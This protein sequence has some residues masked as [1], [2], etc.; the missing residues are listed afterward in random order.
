MSE[1][2]QPK[3]RARGRAYGR[4]RGVP[5]ASQQLQQQVSQ[6]PAPTQQP[7]QVP[8]SQYQLPS[9]SSQQPPIFPPAQQ[10]PVQ[11]RPSAR[12]RGNVPKQMQS[13]ASGVQQARQQQER[14]QERQQQERLQQE[15]QKQQEQGGAY[16]IDPS[17]KE[18]TGSFKAMSVGE[19][20]PPQQGL[21]RGVMRGRLEVVAPPPITRPETL[22]VKRGTMGKPVNLITNHFRLVKTT[23]W[24]LYQYRVDFSPDDESTKLRKGLLGNHKD[25]LGG[26]AYFFD[27]SML[28]VIQRLY[29]PQ[30]NELEL[31]SFK[32]IKNPEEGQPAEVP[33]KITIRFTK[34]L[35]VGDYQYIQLFN[36]ILRNC[37]D[38]MEFQLVGREYFDPSQ[39]L[40]IKNYNLEIWPGYSTSILQYE[41]HIM[42]GLDVSHKVLRSDNVWQFLKACRERFG[43][44]WQKYFLEVILG[45]VV[46]TYYNNKPYRVDD[47]AFDMT[48]LDTFKK[49]NSDVSYLDYYRVKHQ[50]EIKEPNQPLLISRPKARDI[51]GGRNQNIVLI[52]E[53]CQMTG[54]SDEMRSNFN[55]MKAVAD[56]TRVPPNDRVNSYNN[57]IKQINECEKATYKL[58][59]WNVQFAQTLEPVSGRLFDGEVLY[60]ANNFQIKPQDGDWSRALRQCGMLASVRL[61]KWILIASK[62]ATY[63]KR[64]HGNAIDNFL[65]ELNKAARS[66][67]FE[68]RRPDVVIIDVDKI[69]NYLTVI[70][71]AINS[72]G[73]QLVM[74][75][76]NGN[77][78]DLYAAIK[79]K[80]VCDRPIPSQV[81]ATKTLGHKSLLSVCT[82]IVIQMNCKLG[83]S[84]WFTPVPFKDKV[85]MSNGK[86]VENMVHATMIVGFDVCHDTR[87]KGKSVGAM[88][89]SLDYNFSK[90]YSSVSRHSL[91]EELSNDIATHVSHAVIK[92]QEINE[93]LPPKIIMFRDGVGESNIK[94]VIEHEVLTI[95]NRLAQMFPHR[96]PK[97]TVIIVSKRIQ[98]RFFL[99]KGSH[100]LNPPPG[101][102]VDDVVTQPEKYDFFLVSQS[103]RQGT[104]TPTNYNVIFDESKL[105]PDHVQRLAYKMCHL[106][107][108]CTATVRVPCQVQYAHKLAFLVGQV[109]HIPPRDRK[110]VV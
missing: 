106:Y 26:D 100:Y 108:N 42:M 45:A 88:V 81:I 109:I 60:M 44:D 41:D 35:L 31:V 16:G 86:I 3:G 2:Q 36:I 75:I 5:T 68:M 66:L 7:Q 24:S 63:D 96:T 62:Q 4:A 53:F 38:D 48:P 14:Q 98:T 18:V 51:R 54:L 67:K 61:E 17:V 25:V 11:P 32:R 74:C 84:P 6:Q 22:S 99:G 101:T 77:R 12:A 10:Q 107:Y 80:C 102:I 1:E 94:Y 13:G 69:S 15:R 64:V 33:V 50:L 65:G 105:R 20:K 76:I 23:N 47:V 30:K 83:G 90:F 49:G 85:E 70:D 40:A 97:L 58:D 82:K 46:F 43:S 34:E 73:L 92:F 78:S 89:A 95:K 59:I 57:F 8:P 103:V 27:G 19:S 37:M 9:P 71:K 28:F 21:R 93:F 110:S 104:V 72:G 79:K 29:G 39:S 91:G 52:P 55:L 87:V 56:H